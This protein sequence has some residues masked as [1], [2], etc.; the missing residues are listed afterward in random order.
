[1]VQE[2]G[3][4]QFMD[5]AYIMLLTACDSLSQMTRDGAGE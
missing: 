2:H 1:M 4:Y 5:L 3:I